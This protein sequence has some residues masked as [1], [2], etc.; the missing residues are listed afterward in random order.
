MQEGHIHFPLLSFYLFRLETESMHPTLAS[1]SSTSGDP[2]CAVH[3]LLRM[4]PG[5]CAVR[6]ALSYILSLTILFSKPQNPVE[7][8][9]AAGMD[10][11]VALSCSHLTNVKGKWQA[12]MRSTGKGF[13]TVKNMLI[14][15]V[16]CTAEFVEAKIPET[17]TSDR[18]IHKILPI[19]FSFLWAQGLKALDLLCSKDGGLHPGSL[20]L[21]MQHQWTE[22][23]TLCIPGRHSANWAMSPDTLSSYMQNKWLTLSFGFAVQYVLLSLLGCNI[24]VQAVEKIL[25]IV[26]VLAAVTGREEK[27]DAKAI[28]PQI[29]QWIIK[30]TN[31]CFPDKT[32]Q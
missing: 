3:W 30:H 5:L 10:S 26:H 29:T 24:I 8:Q 32:K 13:W 2:R 6:Q 4:N 12:G 23:R 16:R 11:A 19:A 27:R 9:S 31:T 20:C 7:N 18:T 25:L 15:L 28:L 1:N 14:S 21:I 17:S 22:P